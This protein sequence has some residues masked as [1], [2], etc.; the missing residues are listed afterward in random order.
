MKNGVIFILSLMLFVSC[1]KT[2]TFPEKI[3]KR[4][5]N[6]SKISHETVSNI[7][8]N[9]LLT[10]VNKFENKDESFSME[11][12][13]N[14]WQ[15]F[16]SNQT[17]ELEDKK[18]QGLWVEITGLLL[19]LTQQEKYAAELERIGQTLVEA[20]DLITPFI[21]TRN[22]DNIYVNLFQPTEISFSHSMGGKVTFRQETDYPNS[23]SVKLHFGMTE[24]RQIE[25]FI[26]IPSWAEGTTV[27]VKKVKY[28]AGPGSYCQI[29]KKWKEGD[30]VEIEFQ[31]EK[32]PGK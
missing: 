3:T 32:K 18:K 11:A 26:R 17:F 28:F 15:N 29:V 27:T 19:E 12:F 23:G 25:L 24:R 21:L 1:S 14:D 5:G 13:E 2:K 31:I 8:L 16:A 7:D 30:V 9:E 10:Y 4:V 6:A 20:T 22:L